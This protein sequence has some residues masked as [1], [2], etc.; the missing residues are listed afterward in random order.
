MSDAFEVPKNDGEFEWTATLVNINKGHNESLLAKCKPLND[1]AIY[2]DRIKANIQQGLT[3]EEAVKEAMDFAIKNNMLNGFF[4]S[5]KLEVLNMSLTEFN[6]EE[7]DRN[8]YD[9]GREAGIREGK[10]EGK[11]EGFIETA[12]NLLRMGVSQN[13]ITQATG[14]SAEQLNKLSKA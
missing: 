10:L 11:L 13:Q 14:L 4:L 6:Q 2:I 3:K 8:R 1:Y 7:Y 12:K 9:E 5:Q